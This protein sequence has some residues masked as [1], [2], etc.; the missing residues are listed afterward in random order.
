MPILHLQQGSLAFGHVPLFEDADLRI[1]AGDRIA[2]IGRNGTGKSSLLKALA[3]EVPL[4]AGT[5]WRAPGLRI[6]RLEQDVLGREPA[7][8]AS[9]A[10]RGDGESV[11][12][13]VSGG[14]GALGDLV[15]QY[16]HAAVDV[17]EHAGDAA[18]LARLSALQHALELQDGWRLE[19]R[20]EL[21]IDRLGLPA[22]RPIGELSGGWRRRTLLARAL[23]SEPDLLLLDEPTN[24]LDVQAIE[25]LEAF[26]RDFRGAVLFV[27]HDRAFLSSLAT[28]IVDMDRGRVTSWPGSYAAYLEKKSAALDAEERD[29]DRLDRKLAQ[30]EAWLRRGVKARRTRNEGRV[31]ALLALRAERAARRAQ[32]GSAR[33]VIDGAAPTGKMVFEAKGVS[34]SYGGVPVI[35][36]Y[37]QRIL[38]GDRVG[39]IGP[40]GSGKST[41]LRLLVQEIEPDAGTIRHGTRLEI[42]YFDQQREQLDPD[43]TVADTISD[44]NDVVIINGEPKHVIGYLGDFLFPRERAQSP[45]RSLSG[46]ERNR[47]LLARLFARPANVLVLDEPTNDL[48]IETLEL[49]EELVGSFDGT[50][51]LVS[52]DRV[53]LDRVVTSTLAFEGEGRVVEY[54]GGYGD[55]LRQRR[56]GGAEHAA[57]ADTAKS[58]AGGERRRERPRKLSF[59]EQRE[60]DALPDRIAALEEEQRRLKEESAA[61]EFY[62][63]GAAHIDAVLARIDAVQ[64]ELDAA[65][66]RWMQLE[67]VK[68]SS[69]R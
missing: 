18:R 63:A 30:E 64:R 26:L 46:G 14:L 37:S 50:V 59:K 13:V 33:M 41:L 38:R 58:A 20:V 51:L 29:L 40:N 49:L 27:T 43:R 42:A 67:A 66:E 12:D 23:V 15:A 57:A 45:V 48:D 4:D 24:H 22:D 55:Y 54:V 3:G 7:G 2:L 5:L 11:F 19:Q 65:L 25:W 6:A 61:P 17:A 44:G 1:E 31:K 21:V 16:H 10:P 35:R 56:A 52:H 9:A 62:R 34:K 39:L 36:D 53:F 68:E 28:R 8:G 47:L 60:L 32:V 69:A